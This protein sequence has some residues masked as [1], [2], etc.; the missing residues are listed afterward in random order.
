[1]LVDDAYGEIITSSVF[2]TRAGN[3]GHVTSDTV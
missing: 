1:M 3:L 2:R